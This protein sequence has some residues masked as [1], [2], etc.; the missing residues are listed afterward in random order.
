MR[1]TT[2]YHGQQPPWIIEYRQP[3]CT[4]GTYRQQGTLWGAKQHG[5]NHD[6]HAHC[7]MHPSQKGDQ[8]WTEQDLW[9][10]TITTP[11]LIHWVTK[12]DLQ[13]KL[14]TSPLQPWERPW[15]GGIRKIEKEIPPK[16]RNT[17]QGNQPF[18][19]LWLFR[20]WWQSAG[21]T[22]D[23]HQANGN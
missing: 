13:Q 5:K 2:R 1:V 16:S 10:W 23:Y 6:L 15:E 7:E 12:G 20:W 22:K 18:G 3:I 21:K 19:G 14:W 11:H 4:C 17:A 8:R 9:I